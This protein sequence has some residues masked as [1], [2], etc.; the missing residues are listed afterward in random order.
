M[1]Y[2]M[3]KVEEAVLALLGVF[4]FGNG[5]AWK[6]YDFDTMD[7]LRAKGLVTEPRSKRESVELTD[8]G[9]RRAKELAARYFGI[10]SQEK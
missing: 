7:G 1:E 6:R 3:G 10:P 8:E 9:L 2:D 5:R 4:E